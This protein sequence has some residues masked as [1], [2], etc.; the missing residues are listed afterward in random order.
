MYCVPPPTQVQVHNEATVSILTRKTPIRTRDEYL[1]LAKQYHPDNGGSEVAMAHINRLYSNDYVPPNQVQIGGVTYNFLHQHGTIYTGKSSVLYT[2]HPK[3]DVP[4]FK[5]PDQR[6][7]N[8]ISKYLPVYV[9]SGDDWTIVG[10]PKEQ[11]SLLDVRQYLTPPHPTWVVSSLYNILCYL[12]WAG[13]THNAISIENV[14]IDPKLHSAHLYGGWWFSAPLGSPIKY[15]PRS[16]YA[17]AEREA[18]LKV[19]SH[20]FDLRAIKRLGLELMGDRTGMGLDRT[21]PKVQQ[22]RSPTSGSARQDYAAWIKSL[23]D[24]KF[25]KLELPI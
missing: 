19:A 20:V 14:C 24:R 23:G 13:V 25:V 12:E 7:Q 8:E 15:L 9:R 18:K 5:Y 17:L 11:Y 4:V 10:K 16:T 3:H 21:D 6:V 1:K 2:H 22:L